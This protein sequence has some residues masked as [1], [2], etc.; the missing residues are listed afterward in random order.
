MTIH[1]LKFVDKLAGAEARQSKDLVLTIAEAKALH[2]DITR[3][4]LALET[5]NLQ[6]QKIAEDRDSVV[7][8]NVSGG[9]YK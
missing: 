1:I 5:Y 4:L 6:S 8:I 9:S 7:E 3:L 2:Q